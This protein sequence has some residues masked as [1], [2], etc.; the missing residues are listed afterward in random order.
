MSDLGTKILIAEDDRTSAITF[1]AALERAGHDVEVAVNGAEALAKV[2][3]GGFEVLL[4]DWMMP[5]MDGIEL[6]RRVRAEVLPVP[7]II[8]VTAATSAEARE[9]ALGAGADGYLAKPVSVRD[10]VAAVD[11]GLAR[12]SQGPPEVGSVAPAP[13]EVLPPFVG[14]VMASSTGGPQS[15][16]VALAG[17]PANINAAFFLVQHAPTWMLETLASRL[18]V[19]V[20]LGVRS[21]VNGQVP[22]VGNLYIA[23]GDRHLAFSKETHAMVLEEGPKE[24]YVRPSADWLFR[25]AAAAF[26]PYCVAVVLTGLGRD[27]TIGSAHVG[28]MGGRVLAEDPKTAVMPF[29]PQSA[30]TVGVAKEAVPLAGMSAAIEKQVRQMSARL[31]IE[32]RRKPVRRPGR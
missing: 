26:G 15:I 24:N 8:M 20:Q 29:M 2:R 11:D 4:T 3:Y 12:R 31:R 16:G 1:S 25:S 19:E 18:R 30:I 9:L 14:V 13:V 28:A 21:A 32:T 27:G 22:E 6:A 10:L 5:R 17:L 23:A 7:L